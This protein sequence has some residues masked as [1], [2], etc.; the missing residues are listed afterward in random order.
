MRLRVTAPTV[1]F[2][3]ELPAWI[4][5]KG[6]AFIEID[7]RPAG[8]INTEFMAA[9][10]EVSLAH[11]LA[12]GE[13]DLRKIRAVNRDWIAAIYD[14]CVI[15]WRTNLVDGDTDQP[16]TCDRDTFLALA[17]VKVSEIAKAFIDFQKEIV[18][19]GERVVAETQA[20]IKN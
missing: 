17:E 2:R 15:A 9:R 3:A 19:A 8:V 18:E 16:L 12:D 4:D 10:E 6:T 11:V 14:T 1:K 7:A 20:T 5:P 13:K